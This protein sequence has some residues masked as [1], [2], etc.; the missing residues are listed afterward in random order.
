MIEATAATFKPT[1]NN[2]LVEGIETIGMTQFGD[3]ATKIITEQVSSQI[4]IPVMT[5]KARRTILSVGPKCFSC[6]QCDHCRKNRPQHCGHGKTMRA[7]L[8]G[9]LAVL[10]LDREPQ[11]TLDDGSE[12]WHEAHIHLYLNPVIIAAEE[13]A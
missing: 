5:T 1:G 9:W 12:V 11:G 4:V 2:I 6:G 7:K 10:K 13:H 8:P 3:Y